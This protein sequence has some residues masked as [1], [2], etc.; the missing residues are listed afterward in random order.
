MATAGPSHGATVTPPTLAP[1]SPLWEMGAP[2][3]LTDVTAEIITVNHPG[4]VAQSLGPVAGSIPPQSAD[5]GVP[6]PRQLPAH[7]PHFVG[8]AEELRRLTALLDTADDGVPVVI[9]A[10]NGTAGIGKTALAVHWAHQVVD[11]FPDGQLYVNLR[12]FDPT[13]TPM[14]S[15]EAI[16]GFLDAFAVS[17]EQI[18]VGPTAQTTLYR[19]LVSERKMLLVLDN[20]RD[21]DQVRPLLPGTSRCRVVITSRNQLADLVV[22]HGARPITLDVLHTDDA[23]ALLVRHLGRD[24]VTAESDVHT[25]LI[26]QCARLPLALSIVAARAALNPLVGLR[27]LLEELR[28]EQTRLDALDAGNPTTNVRAVF[29]WSYQQLS[30]HAAR[31]FRLLGLHPGPDISPP[32]AAS[33]A[34]VPPRQARQLLSELARAHLVAQNDKG[35]FGFHDLLRVYATELARAHDI[36]IER[37]TAQQRVLDHY[38]HTAYTAAVSFYPRRDPPAPSPPLDGVTPEQIADSAA[39]LA[40]FHAEHAVLLAVLRL[41]VSAG[42]DTHASGL[43]HLLVDFF[44]RR[45]H[46]HDWAATVHIALSTAQRGADTSGTARAHLDLGRV[47]NRLGHPAAAENHLGQAL[48]MFRAIGDRTGEA[49]TYLEY[50][51]V[52]EY[53]NR[54]EEG[55]RANKHALRGYRAVGDRRGQA[56]ALNN[57]G[58]FHALLGHHNQAVSYARRALA[59]Y[60]ELGHRRGEAY[61]LDTLG[62]ALHH[63]GDHLGAIAHYRQSLT[64]GR[65]IGDMYNEAAVLA[66]LGDSYHATGDPQTARDAWQRALDILDKLGVARPRSLGH[67]DADQLRAK[68]TDLD[69]P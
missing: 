47:E 18:P 38:L 9:S 4:A 14:T 51:T 31:M 36:T 62:Y 22:Q 65:E 3:T 2:I 1:A 5:P 63:L 24:R 27:V 56:M 23:T 54:H 34:G 69:L 15:A 43:P 45:G 25:E 67:S 49:H 61:T 17:P 41:A 29:S 11:R 6:V 33:L 40:W 20:A 66:H 39:A 7:V 68:L 12:G 59:L 8:R 55:L 26:E 13:D 42:H 28:D 16:R 57:L 52:Y 32:A 35:R 48:A 30:R 64:A 60:R 37:Q 44:E 21:S 10:I 58:W 50:S 46:W 19:R 53:Q